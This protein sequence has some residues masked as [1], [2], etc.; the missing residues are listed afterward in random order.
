MEKKKEEMAEVHEEDVWQCIL[1]AG[2]DPESCPLCHDTYDTQIPFQAFA[3]EAEIDVCCL[4]KGSGLSGVNDDEVCVLCGG[5][6]LTDDSREDRRQK[7][8]EALEARTPSWAKAAYSQLK[9]NKKRQSD[10]MTCTSKEN[11]DVCRLCEGSADVL[12]CPFCNPKSEH[13]MR[14]DIHEDI[15]W[16]AAAEKALLI[17]PVVY[18]RGTVRARSLPKLSK[19]EGDDDNH[20]LLLDEESHELVL[21]LKEC[22]RLG[23]T[24]H[25]LYEKAQESEYYIDCP[26]VL[27]GWWQWVDTPFFE[28]SQCSNHEV[29]SSEQRK[30]KIRDAA[31]ARQNV[32]Q[33]VQRLNAPRQS[34]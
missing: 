22:F 14:D 26:H 7:A 8:L 24:K 13:L 4:C 34:C 17:F 11:D 20:K 12:N 29:E 25:A 33:M 5:E 15:L 19:W 27:D 21:A 16:K 23:A 30:Q 31:E 3:E 32:S 6:K 1:C 28:V 10:H 18:D 9:K 2:S